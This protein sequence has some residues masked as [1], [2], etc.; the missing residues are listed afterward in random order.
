MKPFHHRDE[1]IVMTIEMVLL[2][3]ELC[4]CIHPCALDD[5][6]APGAQEASAAS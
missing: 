3:Y 2:T 5:G 1:M 6:A 4:T